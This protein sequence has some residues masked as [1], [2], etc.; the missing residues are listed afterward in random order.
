MN[1]PGVLK[2][3]QECPN[4]K[5]KAEDRKRR[6]CRKMNGTCNASNMNTEIIQAD[7]SELH[8]SQSDDIIIP[9]QFQMPRMGRQIVVNTVS[10]TNDVSV[11]G[12]G[13]PHGFLSSMTTMA[14]F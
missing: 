4:H 7:I 13:I 1:N 3:I 6:K 12:S 10:T 2:M 9:V 5:K 14:E 8:T 11:T